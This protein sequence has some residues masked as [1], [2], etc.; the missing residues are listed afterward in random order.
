MEQ[1]SCKMGFLPTTMNEIIYTAEKGYV[2]DYAA[3][4]G[5]SSSVRPLDS[6]IPDTFCTCILLTCEDTC[7]TCNPTCD[8]PT[9]PATC[10]DTCGNTCPA[11]TCWDTCG[12]PVTCGHPHC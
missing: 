8:D 1:V 10:S 6:E 4:G 2:L 12:P 3:G 7:V 5:Y 11:I 9:C